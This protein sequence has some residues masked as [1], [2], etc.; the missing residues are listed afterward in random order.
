MK[1]D[2]EDRSEQWGDSLSIRIQLP[3]QSD[4]SESETSDDESAEE[5]FF[6]PSPKGAFTRSSAASLMALRNLPAQAHLT[7]FTP[8][9][10]PAGSSSA[11]LDNPATGD[12]FELLGRELAG[13][14]S[15]ICHMPYVPS[16][17]FTETHMA[18]VM[19]SD[20]IITVVCEPS[21]ASKTDSMRE[22]QDFAETALKAFLSMPTSV[23]DSQEFV[24]IQCATGGARH[25][26]PLAFSNVIET[27]SYNAHTAG[28][29]AGAI[30][31]RD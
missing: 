26:A 12:P 10:T 13:H 1:V 2:T 8:C 7:L 11:L 6:T 21:R 30:L 14:H 22:Q 28:Y 18:F 23:P 25:Q 15:K 24:L 3:P 27:S 9:L 20:A 16:V 19:Q 29:L 4:T 31:G 17:G 5:L